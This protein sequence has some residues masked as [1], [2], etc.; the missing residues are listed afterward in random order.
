MCVQVVVEEVPLL[1]SWASL[2]LGTRRIFRSWVFE[3][4]LNSGDS[5][6]RLFRPVPLVVSAEKAHECPDGPMAQPLA[7][8]VFPG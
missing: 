5:A 1:S 2:V 4:A 3:A 7:D 8:V 6:G